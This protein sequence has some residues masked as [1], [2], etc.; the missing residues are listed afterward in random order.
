MA[1]QR[2]KFEHVTRFL[3]GPIIMWHKIKKDYKDKEIAVKQ[4]E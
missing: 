4:L 1:R 2:T 3:R